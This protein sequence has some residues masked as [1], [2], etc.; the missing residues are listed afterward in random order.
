MK[1]QQ[2]PLVEEHLQALASMQE[3]GTDDFFYTRLQAR[4]R[5]RQ[6]DGENQKAQQGWSWP[7]KPAW[8][9]TSLAL[10][11]VINGFMLTKR[12]SNKGQHTV[13]A[14]SLQSFAESY[15]QS[16]SSSY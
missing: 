7:V 14:P 6:A 16:I 10:L 11:L 8:V 5:A 1:E 3:T 13:Q 9:I 15:D 12:Y 4:M 2:T